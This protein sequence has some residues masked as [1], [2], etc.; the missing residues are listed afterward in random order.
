[1][2]STWQQWFERV[3]RFDP[4]RRGQARLLL[5]RAKHGSLP[6]HPRMALRVARMVPLREY[7]ESEFFAGDGAPAEVVARRRDGFSRLAA[8]LQARAP[9]T[10]ARSEE[11]A[12][13]LSDVAFV[14][15]YRVPFQYRRHVRAHLKLGCLVAASDGARV[16]DLDGNWSYDLGGSYGVNLFG[17]DFYRRCIDRGVEKAR[18]LGMVLGAYHPI[19]L[20]NVRRLQAVSGLDEVSFHMSGT[21]AVMQAVRLARYHTGRSHVVRFCGAYHGWWDG[22]QAGVG[23]PRPAGEVY[24]LRELDETTLEVLRTRDDIACVLVNPIQ[25]MAPNAAPASDSTLV[26]SDRAAHVDRAAY[27][28]WLR[29]LREVCSARGIVLI[30][31]EVFLGF[32]LA[33]GGAQEYF[34][35]HADLV[36]YGKTVG[37]GLPVGVLCGRR[38]LMRRF[39]PDRPA[40]ICFARGT[41]NS[42]PYVMATMNEFLRHL[43]EPAVRGAYAG[44]DALWDGRAAALNERLA[45]LEAPVR[46]VNLT[47]VWTTL[48]TRPS[49]YNWMLQFYLRAAGLS[50]SWVGT[51]RF[52]F[53]HDLTDADF[54]AI[55][56]RICDGAAAMLADG[57]WS[58][59]A[60]LTDRAIKR[61]VLRELVSARL[62]RG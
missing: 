46:F 18:D 4:V 16:Q 39:R 20:D 52:I 7:D 11:L 22:V 12:Q 24:T 33:L 51:G 29:R 49:R 21:E 53:S 47:S 3:R 57:W 8:L 54:A 9:Q 59:P 19:V 50:M 42:H 48:Y 17:V 35:V 28:R 41:F 56:R 2:T 30:F 38:S 25:A 45:R 40:D 37:G 5:S 13:G 36:T 27:R 15:M 34:G 31:D 43:D 26:A 23:N 62:G 6:G 1:M 44:L 14:D 55:S 32:R 61:R 10:L 58:S 60:G